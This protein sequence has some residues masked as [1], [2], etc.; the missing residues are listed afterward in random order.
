MYECRLYCRI[1]FSPVLLYTY[2]TDNRIIHP[3]FIGLIHRTNFQNHIFCAKRRHVWIF[4]LSSFFH[5]HLLFLLLLLLLQCFAF[6][7][8]GT[9]MPGS[10]TCSSYFFYTIWIEGAAV[11]SSQQPNQSSLPKTV[12]C[13]IGRD[14]RRHS[15]FTRP[16]CLGGFW[17]FSICLCS[18][19]NP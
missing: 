8:S 11:C 18:K 19:T 15:P 2:S 9:T 7:S 10:F 14:S 1:D 3:P 12:V 17:V 6:T 13:N 16:F 5:P 4:S